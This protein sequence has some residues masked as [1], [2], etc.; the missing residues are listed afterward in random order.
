MIHCEALEW[1]WECLY[2]N[3]SLDPIAALYPRFERVCTAPFNSNYFVG[4]PRGFFL[5]T[6]TE[7]E[8]WTLV[9]AIAASHADE[10][11]AVPP[12]AQA[13]KWIDSFDALRSW[14]VTET[15]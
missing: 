4:T 15:P 5:T 7:L 13:L 8:W 1:A 12:E 11:L 10:R 3:N 14:L 6:D 9:L 2:L